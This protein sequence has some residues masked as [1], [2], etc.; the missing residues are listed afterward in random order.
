MSNQDPIRLLCIDDD[1]PF[2]RV[3]AGELRRMGLIVDAVGDA[4]SAVVAMDTQCYDVALVDLNLPGM[5][6]EELIR[7]LK[8]RSP[9]T[10]CIVL[11]GH[12]TIDSAVRTLKDGAYDFLT[13]PCN[14]EE[15]EAVIRKAAEKR[16][17]VRANRA[18]KHELERRDQFREFVGRSEALQSVLTLIRSIGVIEP[19]RTSTT[20]GP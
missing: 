19:T 20:P 12:G 13:K 8:E 14:L 9:S 3:L 16:A 17:L 4:E 7:V 1:E 18:L 15:L 10:E 2:R 5:S 6:G 11:S